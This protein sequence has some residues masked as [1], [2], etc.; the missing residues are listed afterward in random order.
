MFSISACTNVTRWRFGHVLISFSVST[1]ELENS[2][3][4]WKI[5]LCLP[6]NLWKY[7]FVW[8]NCKN[9]RLRIPSVTRWRKKDQKLRVRWLFSSVRSIYPILNTTFHKGFIAN[10]LRYSIEKKN[11]KIYVPLLWKTAC[12]NVTRWRS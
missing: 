7:G 2:L 3:F 9:M 1:Y 4:R 11:S 12:M 10:T 6:S 5:D 8:M